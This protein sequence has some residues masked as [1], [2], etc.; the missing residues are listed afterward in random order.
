MRAAVLREYGVPS[1]DDFQE[2]NAGPG[3]A[4][5]EVAAAGLNPVDVAICAGSYYA[6]KPALPC[7]AGREGI[8]LLD[9]SRVY[10]DAPVFP[11]G[12][13][14]ERVLVDP[15]STYPVPDAIEDAVAVALGISG[16]T[17]WLALSWRAELKHG[18]HVLVL[19][20]S[21]VLGQ[22]AVQAAR[23]LGAGRVVAAARS[24]EGLERCLSLGA[25]AA[26]RLG[27]PDDLPGALA[28]AADG[29]IDVVID[30][31]FGQPFTA[32][33]SAASF[34]ARIVQLGGGAGAEAT[35]SSPV[36]RGKMLVISGLTLAAAPPELKADAYRRLTDAAAA[37]SIVVE[38][39][40]FPL[41]RVG[42]A[43]ERLGAGAHRKVVI[44]P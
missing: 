43:W 35:V 16:L 23:L 4:V 17:A 38:T 29:R 39:Q 12:S 30:P 25:D 7:V 24:R 10:F 36:I 5:V 42:D 22:I 34:G 26:V 40:P 44:V 33:L 28:D 1:A 18:E 20:A 41:E 15:Q 13:M 27:E 8:G 9:G 37:A 14:A 19:A 3:Q 6:G 11:F 32:A 31:L 21:G 2:P